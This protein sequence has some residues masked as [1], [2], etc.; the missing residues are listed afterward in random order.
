MLPRRQFLKVGLAGTALLAAARWLDA[1][2]ATAP[3]YR[4][5]DARSAALVAALVPVV[6]AGSLPGEARARASAVREVVAAFDRAIAAL[7]PVVQEEIGQLLAL[8]RYAPTRLALAGLWS[9]VEEST[10]AEIAGFLA[11]WRAS[12]FDLLHAGYQALTQLLQASWYDNPA[13]WA[14]IG[15]PG[16]PALPAR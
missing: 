15:Y 1:P 9:P 12:R 11:A 8:L 10:P 7:N 16:P 14:A 6:L 4:V 2:A 13:S 3:A 5:L